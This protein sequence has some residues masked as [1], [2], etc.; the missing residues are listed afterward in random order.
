MSRRRGQGVGVEMVDTLARPWVRFDGPSKAAHL[1]LTAH[2]LR[3]SIKVSLRGLPSDS[4]RRGPLT[5]LRMYCAPTS[6]ADVE[7]RRDAGR[8]ALKRRRLRVL[9]RRYRSGLCASPSMKRFISRGHPSSSPRMGPSTR[10]R[11]HFAPATPAG[12]DRVVNNRLDSLGASR[13]ELRLPRY[14]GLVS[15]GVG[16]GGGARND[17]SRLDFVGAPGGNGARFFASLRLTKGRGRLPQLAR[18]CSDEGAV[19][20]SGS[21]TSPS[22][23]LP[24]CEGR[25]RVRL[26]AGRGTSGDGALADFVEAFDECVRLPRWV[27][28]LRDEERAA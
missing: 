7:C 21:G 24:L 20:W 28:P 10:L 9:R 11:M 19:Q 23:P 16:R 3:P 12:V 4:P 14:A 17:D 5:R 6:P 18:P 15:L 25:A 26:P 1:R 22:L 13:M 8:I 27:A 2:L